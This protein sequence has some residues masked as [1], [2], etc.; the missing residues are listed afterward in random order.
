MKKRRGS[1]STAI[2]LLLSFLI[3]FFF[4]LYDYRRATGLRERD[5][6]KAE[7]ALDSV[8]A[9]YDRPLF[10]D[11]D[12]LFRYIPSESTEEAGKRLLQELQ[13]YMGFDGIGGFQSFF[14][15]RLKGS[16]RSLVSAADEDGGVFYREAVKSM[17][18]KIPKKGAEYLKGLVGKRKSLEDGIQKRKKI[19][20]EEKKKGKRVQPLLDMGEEDLGGDALR[21]LIDFLQDY[22]YKDLYPKR[23]ALSKRAFPSESLPDR[24]GGRKIL[25]ETASLPEEEH[26]LGELLFTAFLEEHF[27]SVMTEKGEKETEQGLLRYE[28]EYL[29]GGEI[30]DS[31]NL[32]KSR[33]AILAVRS[34]MNFLFL[35]EHPEMREE[36][37]NLSY[38]LASWVKLPFG[39]KLTEGVILALWSE[40]EARIDMKALYEGEKVPFHKKSEEWRLP[41]RLFALR[42]RAPLRTKSTR[43]MDYEEYLSLLLLGI[44]KEERAKRAMDLLM[45]GR[46]RVTPLFSFEQCYFSAECEFRDKKGGTILFLRSYE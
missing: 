11:Y 29:F 16:L 2:A 17:K 7:L 15:R 26:I 14:R 8:F 21:E 28:R 36:A 46:R 41:F 6:L 18:Y 38:L 32:K 4:L 45:L 43:G 31:G 20:E 22:L 13:T 12:L 39:Q 9:S 5:L 40:A 1:L 24:L 42:E 34:L 3:L 44:P 23:H 33:G 37:R 35:L 25:A 19:L 10:R 30:R 27:P